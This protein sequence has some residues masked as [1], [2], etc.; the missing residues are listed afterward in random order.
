MTAKRRTILTILC[1]LGLILTFDLIYI[2]IK[3]NFLTGAPKS[4]CS[5]NGFI[6]CDGVANTK[7]AFFMGVPLA[8]WGVIL[9]LLFLFL[10]WVDK[11]REK[12]KWNLL[13]VFKNPTSYIAT[14]GLFSFC[15][16]IGLALISFFD[17]KKLCIVCFCTY[18]VNFFI[19]LASVQKDFFIT[20]I[21]NTVLDF[22]DGAKRHLTLF[23]AVCILFTSALAYFQRS[24]ILAPNLKLRKSFEEFEKLETNI[25][26]V[27]GNTLG[28]PD[29]DVQIFIHADFMCPFCRTM[30]MMLHK[31]AR[32][33]K[34]IVIYHLNFPLDSACN[35]S[36][37][38]NV[39]PGSCILAKYAIAAGEQDKYWDMVSLIYDNKPKNEDILINIAKNEGF[40]V[41]KLYKDAHSSA[42]DEYLKNQI[43]RGINEGIIATPTL[44]IDGIPHNEAMPYYRL[45]ELVKQSRKRHEKSK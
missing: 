24:L 3:A 5:I 8:I 33:D 35:E 4:F 42:V 45:K 20:D 31:L 18:F 16:S 27:S 26:K 43:Y 38:N 30:N 6:D 23:L 21:K 25:Y 1:I 15:C 10:T 19:A 13:D 14:I 41:E 39:H 2:Y 29:G 44:I 37:H 17:I 11:I 7:K 36:V 34:N 28:N 12:I 9:Y 22:I 40:N 32:E